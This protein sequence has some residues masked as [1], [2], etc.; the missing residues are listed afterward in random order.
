MVRITISDEIKQQLL[1]SDGVVELCDEQGNTV[2]EM[3]LRGKPNPPGWVPMTPELTP[4]ELQKRLEYD[5]PGITTEE[6][7][8]RLRAKS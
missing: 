6:L 3:T 8:K 2:V 4:E 7:I 1:T 5:G